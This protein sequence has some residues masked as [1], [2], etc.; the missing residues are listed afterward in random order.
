MT[1]AFLQCA[2]VERAGGFEDGPYLECKVLLEEERE[3]LAESS[4][5]AER[6]P[7]WCQSS[8]VTASFSTFSILKRIKVINVS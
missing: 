4:S 7:C 8:A 2:I 6:H 5:E 3:D 1:E